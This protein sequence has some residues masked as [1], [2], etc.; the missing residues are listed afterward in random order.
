MAVKAV[1][2]KDVAR[3]LAGERRLQL[4]HRRLH[5]RVAGLPHHRLAAEPR[6]LVEQR[7]ARLDV[8]E[9][10][11]ARLPGEHLGGEDLHQLIAEQ[12]AAL[13]VDHADPIA[14]A[15]E[16][17]A[18]LR[19]FGADRADQCGEV[20]RHGRVG[21]MVG[22]IAVD[23]GEQQR[24]APRQPR[25]ERLQH[26]ARGAIAGIPHHG[27]LAPAGE[28]PQQALDIGVEHRALDDPAAAAREPALGGDPA[29]LL[30]RSPNSEPLPSI[31]LK[32]L[33]LGGLCEPVTWRPP[34]AP[35]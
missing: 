9:D 2:I 22:E 32:P 3:H 28:V 6:D 12:D 7:L 27:E 15:I 35:R 17:D 10:R 18:E 26:F 24:V 14:V 13:A 30:M 29:E 1:G 33:W 4:D 16:G 34:S 11:A 20:L 31:I 8:G 5:Q 19:A 23:L 25:G 21:V